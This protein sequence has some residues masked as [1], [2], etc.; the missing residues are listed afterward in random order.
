MEVAKATRRKMTC[1]LSIDGGGIRGVIPATILLFFE[2][3]L[4]ILDGPDVR[5]ADYF[6]VIAGTSTGG[7]IGGILSAPNE[8]GRPLFKAEDIMKFYTE[9]GPKIFA[10]R[11]VPLITQLVGPKHDGDVLENILDKNL[12]DLKMK[13]TLSDL[14][15]PTFDIKL[16]QPAYFS[17]S[18][19]QHDES[20]N[21][22]VRDVLRGTS[23]A[24]TYFAPHIF[25][26]TTSSGQTR[27]FNLVDG[28]V[29]I[30]NPAHLSIAHTLYNRVK[31]E[32]GEVSTAID[33][34]GY[35][36]L[37]VLSLGTG[38]VVKSYNASDAANWGILSWVLKDG[39]VPVM[40]IVSE[41]SADVVDYNLSVLFSILQ[42][43]ENYLRIQAFGISKEVQTLDNVASDNI[44]KLRDIG[45]KLLDMPVTNVNVESGD[46][47]VERGLGTNKEALIRFA[48]EL[49]KEYRARLSIQ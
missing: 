28:G 14:L 3:Q 31:G 10:R 19:A 18:E 1:I 32:G 37:L 30:N 2:Q 8:K 27:A 20:K 26:T 45:E 23:A 40:D 41:C 36:N 42:R 7:I 5:I 34:E 49:S 15:I 46:T 6:D 9:E 22:Y 13:D 24:P 25:N 17:T 48:K 16:M 21:A 44:Q 35:R 12:K 4:Q 47:F 38:K 43:P 29:G 39:Q 11:G 33:I